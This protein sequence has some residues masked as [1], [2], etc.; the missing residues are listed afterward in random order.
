[1]ETYRLACDPVANPAST[2]TGSTYRFT[3][4]DER[5]LRYE[6]AEDGSFENR[7][8]TF[9]LWRNFPEPVFRIKDTED[10][11]E[12]IT[13]AYH[14]TYDKQEFSPNGFLVQFTAKLTSYGAEW[15]YG[16]ESPRNLGGTART[17]DQI[18]GRCDMGM[19]IL[20]RAGFSVLDDTASMLFNEHGFPM[21]RRPG[22]RVDGYIF[23]YG[24]NYKGAM[25]S[26]YAI[27][28]QQ[29]PVPRWCLGNWW[30][31]YHA[32]DDSEYVALM[33][34]F[35]DNNIPLSVAVID[36]DWHWVR[37]DFVPNTGWTGYSWNTNLFPDPKAFTKSLRDR[38]LKIT[39]NDHPHA[40]VHSF[41]DVY[42]ELA[43]V[44]GHDTSNR[45]PIQFDPTSSK[46][47]Y[48][49]FNTIHRR[50]E[51]IGCD[52]WWIDW[53]QGSHSRIPG[54]D[55]LWLL[56][57]FQYLDTK[58]IVSH[59]LP[60]IFSRY[61]GPGS[62]RYPVGFSGD[63]VATW[64]S[65]RFQPEFTATAS[66]IGFGWWSHDI[67]GHLRGNRD[68][69]C[70]TRWIQFAV[71]SPALRLHSSKDR[72]QSKEPW[73][74]RHENQLAMR[75]ALQFRHRL[76]PYI[77]SVAS[78][79]DSI[80]PLVQPLY[81]NFPALPV[82][83]MYPN[84]YLFGPSLVVSPIVDPRDTRTNLAKTRVW[85]PPQRH[86]D[87]FT[88]TIYDGDRELDMY[89]SL[90]SIPVLAPEGAIIPLDARSIPANGC[91]NPD[92][93]E[94]IV[95]VGK[96]GQF[97]LIEDSEDDCNQNASPSSGQR[98]L[99]IAYDQACG[100]LSFDG[101][102]K[103]W[104]LRFVSTHISPSSITVHCGKLS[105]NDTGVVQECYHVGSDTVLSLKRL[106]ANTNVT[107][108][109]GADPQLLVHDH[110][111]SF[112]R[113]LLDFQSE[114]YFKNKIWEIIGKDQPTAVKAGSLLSLD[115]DQVFKGPILELLL[116]DGRVSE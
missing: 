88:G 50:L 82:A 40:G 65:L 8:S 70:T 79:P 54:F 38:D 99:S 95:V 16:Q 116:A 87:I 100:K 15:R 114:F 81:W 102:N 71:F 68:D 108:D 98:C 75:D 66:N 67:G 60:I 1:M 73:L 29:P 61:A 44:L 94:I 4:I 113:L 7:A 74:Y 104:R 109:L 59:S 19:G 57:H 41:E 110:M 10:Q 89:R 9:A 96:D 45:D 51:E 46:Y 83:Y 103:A 6:W 2:I 78:S 69:E 12:I 92:A 30:S 112:N 105:G 90:N 64:A 23:S 115:I 20:G 56:N 48:A 63:T 37:E 27:S 43:R 53:Q 107:I 55:P 47:M 86:V 28:G 106:E 93:F 49:Y 3:V 22:K 39:L 91:K 36:M 25:K 5:V 33:D 84:Q 11:L 34:K 111:E 77:Y 31:R 35:R 17:L 52:F 76:V 24:T 80:L 101:G 62:H 21:P 72:W 14:L 85:I 18:D 13:P 42:E 97:E 32:Y 26:F 58:K